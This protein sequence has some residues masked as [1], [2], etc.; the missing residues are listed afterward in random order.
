M[1]QQEPVVTQRRAWW[2]SAIM[3]VVGVLVFVAVVVGLDAALKPQLT[4]TALMLIGVLLAIIPAALWLIFFYFQDRLEPEPKQEV[5]KIFIVGLALAGA[6]GIPVT[7]QLFGVQDWLYRSTSSL[8]LGSIFVI[9]AIETLLIYVTVRFFIYDSPEFDERTDGM[10]YGTAAG[11]GYATALNIAFI[12]GSGGAA[13]GGAEVDVAEVALAHAAFA[14]VLGYFL[15]RAKMEREKIWWLPLGVLLATLFNGVFTIL[16][17]R[18][19]PGSI[20]LGAASPLPAISGLILAGALAVIV[21]IGISYLINRD[22]AQTTA[23]GRREVA[24]AA[25]GDRQSNLAAIILAVVL[26]VVGIAATASVTGAV[27]TFD[28]NGFKGAYPAFFGVSTQQ[29]EVLRVSDTMGTAAQFTIQTIDLQGGED[30]KKVATQL[31]VKRGTGFQAYKVLDFSDATVSG[32]P[33][34]LQRFAYVDTRELVKAIP[35]LMEGEDYIVVDGNRAIII[36]MLT[37]PDNLPAVEPMFRQFV[38]R[39]AF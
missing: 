28:V 12:L 29:G 5:F 23:K 14:G 39:L 3:A 1:A 21:A 25:A 36:T 10:V 19:V 18:L 22:I 24:D 33:A 9:G 6:I 2:Q 4:G 31:A 27:T 16:G 11:L 34:L 37:T 38:D 17:S 26:I 20:T 30:A 8:V 7:T 35:R 13:L 32:K 15:G